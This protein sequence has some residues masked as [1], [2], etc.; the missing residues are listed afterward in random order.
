MLRLSLSLCVVVFV[1]TFLASPVRPEEPRK[2][3]S[4]LL[5]ISPTALRGSQQK[6]FE[7]EQ[8]VNDLVLGTKVQGIAKTSG[9]CAVEACDLQES[10][11]LQIV[12]KGVSVTKSIGRNGPAVIHST[13]TTTFTATAPLQFDVD[14]G[15]MVSDVQVA[16]ETT[17]KTDRIESTQGGIAGT[18]VKKLAAKKVAESRE[19]AQ[20]IARGLA[21]NRIREGVRAELNER[22]ARINETHEHL[23]PALKAMCKQDVPWQLTT[24]GEQLH[25]RL[26]GAEVVSPQALPELVVGA[27][28][29]APLASVDSQT[30][31]ALAEV[32]RTT[33]QSRSP[34]HLPAVEQRGGWLIVFAQ[35][36]QAARQGSE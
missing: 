16:A 10:G 26:A 35:T 15:L 29:V 34:E 1:F 28:I 31:S 11:G 6:S 33:T 17:M 9:D 23:L 2:P 30:G 25:I 24:S 19:A 4:V 5:R 18:V 27:D 36:P 14:Q 8:E 32:T 20:E 7:N 13:T 21:V 12:V 3:T 22:V